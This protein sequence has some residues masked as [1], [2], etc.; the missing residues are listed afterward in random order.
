[1]F[2]R[3]G[4]WVIV[5][6]YAK[7]NTSGCTKEALDFTELKPQFDKLNVSLL[8]ISRDSVLSHQKFIDKHNLGIILLSDPDKEVLCAYGAWGLKK[9]YGKET[10]GTIRSTFIIDPEGNIAYRLYNVKVRQKRKNGEVKHA[11]V[12]LEKLKELMDN[13]IS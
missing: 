11:Q 12:V 13:K 6:F 8:S 1:M 7:D 9:Q 5:Y 10:E 3:L 4:R 2:R